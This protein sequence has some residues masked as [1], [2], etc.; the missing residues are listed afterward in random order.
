M[1]TIV[2]VK[3]LI[4][5]GIGKFFQL[6]KHE[7]LLFSFSLSQVGEFA[8]VL[9]AYIGTLH[10]QDKETVDLMMAVTALS[11]TVTPVL[12][13]INE[14]IILPRMN[15]QPVNKKQA[16]V[17]D[18]HNKVIIA[19]FSHFGSTVGRFLR[20]NNVHATI[21]DNDP[22]RVDLLRKMGF[23]VFYGDAT[24][25]DLLN[26]AGAEYAEIFI[27]AIDEAGVNKEIIETVKKY[28]PHLKIMVRAKHRYDAYELMELE[29]E[30]IYREHID[31]SI[32]LGVD[33]LRSLGMRSYSAH[34]AG[35][36]FFKYDEA[37]LAKL[38]KHRHDLRQYIASVR[39]EIERQEEL[40]KTDIEIVPNTN[41]HAWDS[42]Q[43][44]DV[45]SKT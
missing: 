40:L 22:D 1:V 35:Q 27:S 12:L 2:L 37:S 32:R 38:S 24:R 7:N 6:K 4:L 45:I 3:F 16:D 19:G 33:V 8:F 23:K 41:D 17:I 21:L 28:F 25:L 18:E 11:M 39:E 5:A 14:K 43:M 30:K 10:I 31:T 26:S 34:R 36:N 9:F 15:I 44:R 29:P 42:Q 13:L 20:A